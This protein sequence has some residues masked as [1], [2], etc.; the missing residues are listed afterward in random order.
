[1]PAEKEGVFFRKEGIKAKRK[2]TGRRRILQS[3]TLLQ[4]I[5]LV[6][7]D[8]FSLELLETASLTNPE[9]G[10]HGL[11]EPFV[12]RDDNDS[13]L[14]LLQCTCESIDRIHIQVISRLHKGRK[15][16]KELLVSVHTTHTATSDPHT[17]DGKKKQ[18]FTSS[19][20]KK[21]GF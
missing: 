19:R 3:L 13:S 8:T 16:E 14:E 11:D 15:K 2:M 12:V 9:L 1:M 7:L 10:T 5:F 6:L 21:W 18:K 4:N 20:I 17:T